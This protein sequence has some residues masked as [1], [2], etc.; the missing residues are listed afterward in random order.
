MPCALVNGARGQR[1]LKLTTR[2]GRAILLIKRWLPDFDLVFVGD[3]GFAALD[4]PAAVRGKVTVVTRLRLD[5]A[6]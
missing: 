2:A 4:L 6:L 3:S 1:H 5:A